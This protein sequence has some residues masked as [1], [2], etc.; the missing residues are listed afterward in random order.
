MESIG[1]IGAGWLGKA[2]AQT[3]SADYSVSI[4]ENKTVLALPQVEAFSYSYP[5]AFPKHLSFQ[6]LIICLPPSVLQS[7]ELFKGVLESIPKETKVIY[8]S[9]TGVYEGCEGIVTEG[10]NIQIASERV[11][12]LR[13]LEQCVLDRF[14]N[15]C[16]LRLAGLVGPQRNPANFFKQHS[17]IPQADEAINLIHQADVVRFCE[18]V[19]KNNFDGIFN[20]VAPKHPSKGYFY[21][22]LKKDMNMSAPLAPKENARIVA[23]ERS[24]MLAFEYHYADL[25]RHFSE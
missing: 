19:L 8:T 9:S 10:S 3:L 4:S 14:P 5:K 23:T 11:Q 24:E 18:A 15:A 2:L 25:M 20:V 16:V 12:L 17:F 13:S 22:T 6:S 7:A 1:I 21:A